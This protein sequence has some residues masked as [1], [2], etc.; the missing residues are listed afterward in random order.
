LSRR[1]QDEPKTSVEQMAEEMGIGGTRVVELGGQE[2]V[3]KILRL[4]NPKIVLATE[5]EFIEFWREA[6]SAISEF[7]TIY[8][9]VPTP[10]YDEEPYTED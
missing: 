9:T 5:S 2:A 10:R 7:L 4:C 3:M 6:R 8:P 1:E